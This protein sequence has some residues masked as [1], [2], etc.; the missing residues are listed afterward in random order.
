MEE[1]SFEYKTKTL[2]IHLVQLSMQEMDSIIRVQ[3]LY[4]AV[5]ISES[6]YTLKIDPSTISLSLVGHTQ[7]YLN[8]I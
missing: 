5:C 4:K 8:L 2:V 1:Q 6:I 7:G 3:I